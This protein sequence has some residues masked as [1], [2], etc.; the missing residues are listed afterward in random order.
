M[1]SQRS[2]LFTRQ[3]IGYGTRKVVTNHVDALSGPLALPAEFP[4]PCATP[5]DELCGLGKS[6]TI[7]MPYKAEP[8][9]NLGDKPRK[10]REKM[11]STLEG[12]K[13]WIR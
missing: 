12:L 13:I 1:A 2:V 4:D 10:S 8:C 6:S 11:G 3:L 5:G 9:R 7:V